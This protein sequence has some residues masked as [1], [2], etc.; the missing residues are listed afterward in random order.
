MRSRNPG[1]ARFLVLPTTANSDALTTAAH[2][3]QRHTLNSDSLS[4]RTS[5]TTLR[6]HTSGLGVP[7]SYAPFT[8]AMNG[9]MDALRQSIT[10][11]MVV[12]VVLY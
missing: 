1:L 4:R 10:V 2:S 12:G 8:I 5:P 7:S 11:V 3:Q 9:Q 6:H